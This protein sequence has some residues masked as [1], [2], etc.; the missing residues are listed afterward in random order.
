MEWQVIEGDCLNI[1][2]GMAG[3]S[4]DIC[5]TSP[6]YN[7]LPTENKPSGL[8]AERK[9]GINL[10]MEK[11]ANG[12]FDHRDEREYQHWLYEVMCELQRITKGI[13]WINHKVRYRNGVAIHPVRFLPFPI[14]SEIIWDRG[15]SMALNCKRFSPSHEVIL[16]FGSPHYWEDSVNKLMSVWRIN[17]AHGDHPCPFPIEIPRRLIRA[18]CPPSGLVLDPFAGSGT[19]GVACT[20]TNHNFIGIEIDPDYCAIARKRIAEAAMQ[21]VLI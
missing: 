10:W 18:S 17:P 12:Y 15:G 19:T 20:E 7:T 6:P 16:G 21:G 4:V 11:A 14:Y 2:H 5:I 9:N 8:H 3:K 13:V 1:M